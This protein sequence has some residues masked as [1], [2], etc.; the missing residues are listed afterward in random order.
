VVVVDDH[1]LGE[2]VE[3]ACRQHHVHQFGNLGQRRGGAFEI[4]FDV[5]PD[6]QLAGEADLLRVGH[7]HDL[8]RA[9][10]D[11]LL[12]P[13]PDC[14]L[15]QPDRLADGGVRS[16]AVLLKLLDDGLGDVV[17]LRPSGLAPRNCHGTNNAA[18]EALMQVNPKQIGLTSRHIV[19]LLSVC[20]SRGNRVAPAGAPISAGT[21]PAGGILPSW[22]K[23]LWIS[24]PAG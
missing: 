8:H 9:G 10:L 24:L 20:S 18:P 15:R 3:R 5:D 4:P 6:H 21:G 1:R 17:Q 19:R 13:L 2:D 23:R 7:R 22:V 16:P 12:D 14:R 11:Q